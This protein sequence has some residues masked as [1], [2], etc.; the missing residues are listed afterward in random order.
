MK[1]QTA[2][3][4]SFLLGQDAGTIP[5]KDL[6]RKPMG[7][8]GQFHRECTMKFVSAYC[9]HQQLFQQIKRK[10]HK[11]TASANLKQVQ[12]FFVRNKHSK[13]FTS[14]AKQQA[15]HKQPVTK[16]RILDV[17]QRFKAQPDLQLLDTRKLPHHLDFVEAKYVGSTQSSSRPAFPN[18]PRSPVQS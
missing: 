14:W 2:Q 16:E 11:K 13:L 12:F 10:K 7:T 18:R 15:Q 4:S 8:P 17:I 5:C 9:Y 3:T 1:P 6:F